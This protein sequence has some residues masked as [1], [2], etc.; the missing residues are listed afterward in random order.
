MS[1]TQ[2]ANSDSQTPRM[3]VD[4]DGLYIVRLTVSDGK[5]E[6]TDEVRITVTGEANSTPTLS[7]ISSPQTLSLGSELRFKL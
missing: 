2:L 7:A 1:R 4:R 5:L 3:I 6:S